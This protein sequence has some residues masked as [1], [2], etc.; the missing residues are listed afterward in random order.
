MPP[1]M[2]G[3]HNSRKARIVKRLFTTNQFD[4]CPQRLLTETVVNPENS[5]FPAL[6]RTAV[7]RSSLLL[8]VM[9]M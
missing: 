4:L 5:C 3:M 9:E 1:L 6:L 8:V 2:T 7:I